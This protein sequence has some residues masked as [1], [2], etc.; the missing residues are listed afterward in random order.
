MCKAESSTRWHNCEF[1]SKGCSKSGQQTL[2][3]MCFLFWKQKR[4]CPHC[5]QI[6]RQGDFDGFDGKRWLCC[7]ECARL[8]HVKCE[9]ENGYHRAEKEY[10]HQ[11]S[12]ANKSIS[13]GYAC[14][15]CRP[16]CHVATVP[17]PTFAGSLKNNPSQ[18]KV[19][20]APTDHSPLKSTKSNSYDFSALILQAAAQAEMK[21]NGKNHKGKERAAVHA[22][23]S[24]CD[25]P[26]S[27]KQKTSV[28][29]R[30]PTTILQPRTSQ[31]QQ[32]LKQQQ[33]GN[34]DKQSFEDLKAQIQRVISTAKDAL[35]RETSS[36]SPVGSTPNS[37]KA[38]LTTIE[39]EDDLEPVTGLTLRTTAHMAAD[40]KLAPQSHEARWVRCSSKYCRKWRRLQVKT[41]LDRLPEPWTCQD[42]TWD[43]G[44]ASCNA[45]QEPLPHGQIVLTKHAITASYIKQKQKF[46]SDLASFQRRLGRPLSRNPTLGGKDLDLCRLYKEV[47]ARG[48]CD[49]VVSTEGT[50]ARIFR[51]LENFSSTVTDASYR[52]RRY[53]QEFLYAYEQHHFFGKP[54]D[55]VI[56]NLPPSN[57][58][59]RGRSSSSTAIAK[60]TPLHSRLVVYSDG[61]INE[62]IKKSLNGFFPGAQII[63]DKNN[64]LLRQPRLNKNKQVVFGSL[65]HRLQKEAKGHLGK[66]PKFS[67]VRAAAEAV[68]IA[69]EAHLQN[70]QRSDWTKIER[71][72]ENAVVE[73]IEDGECTPPPPRHQ[74]GVLAR[75]C[76]FDYPNVNEENS[77]TMKKIV[78]AVHNAVKVQNH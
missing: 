67:K 48:G 66:C 1:K 30:M 64:K 61:K 34:D 43:L 29:S 9:M 22:F 73:S 78:S 40:G 57:T 60:A 50:W 58:R 5:D 3:H 26:A 55:E 7:T 69:R 56:R 18:A 4:S 24:I 76:L 74:R 13:A 28:A 51:T 46:Y 70:F 14:P 23:A 12:K 25:V 19:G 10:R 15:D 38:N 65:R 17:E 71:K 27:K 68:Q 72:P 75:P 2:C 11:I 35:A 39:Q 59:K 47:T 53:Y 45:P 33:Y 52:L 63:T 62:A 21:H 36:A 32:Q 31:P 20:V 54:M 42:N 41:R 49:R 6:Y 44:R 77:K 37:T 8:V 16:A